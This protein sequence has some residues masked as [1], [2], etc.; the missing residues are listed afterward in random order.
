MTSNQPAGAAAARSTSARGVEG[1]D[2]TFDSLAE[3]SAKLVE[4]ARDLG[5]RAVS[6]AGHAV[7][8]L[9]EQ[10][11][12]VVAAGRKKAVQYKE[13]VDGV[14]SDNPFKSVLIAAGVGALLGFTLGRMRR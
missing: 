12:E 9:R 14:I 13:R 1:R 10:G 7:Q 3:E 2:S 6:T 4:D 11:S 8:G 5:R